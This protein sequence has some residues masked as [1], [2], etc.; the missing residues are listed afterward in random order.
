MYKHVWKERFGTCAYYVVS[1]IN[2]SF[3]SLKKNKF[4]PATSTTTWFVNNNDDG[5]SDDVDDGDGDGDSSFSWE[6]AVQQAEG[7]TF[8]QHPFWSA[9]FGRDYFNQ[10]F[11]SHHSMRFMNGSGNQFDGLKPAIKKQ[12]RIKWY[13][14]EWKSKPQRTFQEAR[15]GRFPEMRYKH[16]HV[17]AY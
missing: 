4:L 17:F 12:N 1:G 13:G 8:Y 7:W 9:Q 10:C 2:V 3:I 15:G 16:M 11:F 6:P 14:M 5:N